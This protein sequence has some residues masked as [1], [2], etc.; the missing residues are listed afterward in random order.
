MYASHIHI[1]LAIVLFLLPSQISSY[2]R[3][4]NRQKIYEAMANKEERTKSKAAV[5]A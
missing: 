5:E 4:S 1:Q 2:L 3:I